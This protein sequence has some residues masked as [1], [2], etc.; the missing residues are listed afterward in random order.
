MAYVQ[1]LAIIT[2]VKVKKFSIFFFF[3]LKIDTP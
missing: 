3:F 1:I 2:Y